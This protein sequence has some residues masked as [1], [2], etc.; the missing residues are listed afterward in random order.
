VVNTSGLAER[1]INV[2]GQGLRLA[3]LQ[4]DEMKDSS[5]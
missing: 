3:L 2:K 4:V 5:N 1:L